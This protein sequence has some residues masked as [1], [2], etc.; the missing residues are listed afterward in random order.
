MFYVSEHL[1]R[2]L[3]LNSFEIALSGVVLGAAGN[4][5]FSGKCFGVV[6]AP[7][8]SHKLRLML[9]RPLQKSD[10]F[11]V[12]APLKYKKRSKKRTKGVKLPSV[13]MKL[14]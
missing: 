4:Y 3:A 1:F 14:K 9:C 12:D 2:S 6:R 7:L 5:T 10:L 13:P 8:T 11:I